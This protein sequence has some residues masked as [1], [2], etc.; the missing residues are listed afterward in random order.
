MI[1]RND[2]TLALILTQ[3]TTFLKNTDLFK[4]VYNGE[5]KWMAEPLEK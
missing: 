2:G 3:S 5:K 4:E 1:N